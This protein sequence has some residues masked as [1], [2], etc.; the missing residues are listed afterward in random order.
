LG[1]ASDPDQDGLMYLSYIAGFA[2][3]KLTDLAAAGG[4]QKYN[5]TDRERE[6][7]HWTA[8]GKSSSEVGIILGI[9]ENTV[10]HHLA[11]AAHKLGTV[12]KAH[13]VAISIREGLLD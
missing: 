11:S 7:V 2:F 13:T 5:L 1:D 9:S 3:E 10:N 6:C 8:V 12:N 4:R